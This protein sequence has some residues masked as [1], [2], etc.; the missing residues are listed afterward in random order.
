MENAEVIDIQQDIFETIKKIL[1]KVTV[2][3]DFVIKKEKCEIEV[4]LIIK[5]FID[6][7]FGVKIKDNITAIKL[8][9][10]KKTYRM[11]LV[12][13]SILLAIKTICNFIKSI[14]TGDKGFFK[15]LDFFSLTR[16]EYQELKKNKKAFKKELNKMEE[17]K[18]A[19]VICLTDK[20]YSRRDTLKYEYGI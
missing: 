1:G 3:H 4:G 19:L 10:N 17:G 7:R 9:L 5:K 15:K 14:I 8:C 20:F 2:I 12:T 18:E 11:Y 13:K 16:K 6:V